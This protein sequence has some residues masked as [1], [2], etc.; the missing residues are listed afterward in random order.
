MRPVFLLSLLLCIAGCRASMGAAQK[1]VEPYSLEASVNVKDGSGAEVRK[2]VWANSRFIAIDFDLIE[3]GQI[4]LYGPMV[5]GG[6]IVELVRFQKTV[7]SKGRRAWELVIPVSRDEPVK[8]VASK[9]ET[10]RASIPSMP[11]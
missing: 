6:P 7:E 8:L 11:S 10:A 3:S 4:V 2:G 9:W 1:A 5:Y